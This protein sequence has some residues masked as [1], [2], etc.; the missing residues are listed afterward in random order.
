LGIIQ[1]HKGKSKENIKKRQTVEKENL[2][3]FFSKSPVP[4]ALIP[5][6]FPFGSISVPCNNR[7]NKKLTRR[8]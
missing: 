8:K 5:F 3:R 1:V 7:N 2:K 6:P 4:Y